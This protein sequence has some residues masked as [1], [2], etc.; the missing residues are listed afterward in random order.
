VDTSD[1]NTIAE[2][3]IEL[4]GDKEARRALGELGAQRARDFTWDKCAART[5]EVLRGVAI[6]KR[7]Q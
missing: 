2:A 6:E 1:P 7:E 5:F 3:L 4:L